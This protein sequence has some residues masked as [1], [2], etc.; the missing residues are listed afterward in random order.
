VTPQVF[1]V[2][3]HDVAP[4]TWAECRGLLEWL[5]PYRVPVTLLAV[6]DYHRAGTIEPKSAFAAWLL[7]RRARGD[8]IVLHGYCHRDE[9]QPARGL[10]E[11]LRRRVLTAAEGEFAALTEAGAAERVRDGIAVLRAAG[12]EPAGFVPPAWL[13]ARPAVRALATSGLPYLATREYLYRLPDLARI[14]APSLV[15]STRSRVR[16]RI[17]VLFNTSKLWIRMRSPLLRIALHPADLRFP[18]VMRAWGRH[19][20][21]LSGAR[22]AI[23]ESAYLSALSPPAPDLD[24][25]RALS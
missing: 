6:P 13:I 25:G 20:A 18:E 16:R 17:S 3:L 19:L 7:Q 8:E 24:P 2:S 14:S 10:A 15:Y 1:S 21:V 22:P 12:I 11:F 23:L 5:E 9:A 4:A